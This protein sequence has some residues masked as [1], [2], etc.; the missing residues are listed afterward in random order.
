MFIGC[1]S[2]C[3]F[4]MFTASGT[5][6]SITPTS[7]VKL[8]ELSDMEQSAYTSTSSAIISTSRKKQIIVSNGIHILYCCINQRSYEGKNFYCIPLGQILMRTFLI[9]QSKLNLSKFSLDLKMTGA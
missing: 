4:G 5:S 8:A 7:T 1:V 6:H 9:K 2:I 3:S